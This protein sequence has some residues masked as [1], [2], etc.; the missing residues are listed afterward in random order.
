MNYIVYKDDGKILRTGVCSFKTFLLQTKKNEFV[1]EGVANDI[2]QKIEFGGLDKKGQP[3]N[4]KVVDKTL[5]EIEVDNPKP[6]KI[7]FE[8]QRA[9]ITNERLQSI[10]DRLKRLEAMPLT[11]R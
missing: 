1:F 4:P 8:K 7:P 11:K 6:L 9:C 5:A 3:I 10:L 2:T